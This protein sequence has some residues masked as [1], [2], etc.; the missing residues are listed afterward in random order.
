MSSAHH[1]YY[2]SDLI[3]PQRPEAAYPE[4]QLT[5]LPDRIQ[6][7]IHTLPTISIVIVILYL[8]YR[9]GYAILRYCGLVHLS[10]HLMVQIRLQP[11]SLCSFVN[12][13][14]TA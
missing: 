8:F 5:E 14:V 2:Q 11:Q 10:Y 3:S 6:Y 7:E 1:Y 4:P 9:L 12:Q 13:L